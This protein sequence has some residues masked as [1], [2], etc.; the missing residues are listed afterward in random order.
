[1]KPESPVT[2]GW[3]EWLSLPG[4][5][6]D[7]VK[8]KVDTGARTS[9]LHAFEIDELD[10]GRR[11]R[12][13]VHP[14]QRDTATVVECF[15]DVIDRRIVSDSGGHREQRW[16]ISTAVV[17]GPH[18]WPAEFTLTA[19]DNMLFRV[20]LGRTAIKGLALVDP[21]R[22]YLVGKAPVPRHAA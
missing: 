15:A 6:I 14:L 19:R 10:G 8:A 11:L 20:L 2:L 22:A 21:S 9:A 5:G 3:K 13:L 17:L 16:V 12:F 7:H 18:S 1:M 4:L